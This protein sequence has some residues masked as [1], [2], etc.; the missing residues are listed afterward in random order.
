MKDLDEIREELERIRLP[1]GRLMPEDV[2]ERARDPKSA[3]HDCFL[4]DDSEAAAQ[5]RLYQARQL[6]RVVVTVL[7]GTDTVT[8]M[9]VSL[10]RD[11]INGGGYR[12]LAVVLRDPESR[13]ALLE[14]A[15]KDAQAFRDRYSHLQEVAGIIAAIDS[16]LGNAKR[17]TRKT[18]RAAV[19][20]ATL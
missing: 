7:P 5:Y 2:V 19:A 18:R 9:N 13:A 3:L 20:S 4:W 15:R 10:Y 17:T 1:D 11:R 8:R 6:L 12:S 14:D 16:T